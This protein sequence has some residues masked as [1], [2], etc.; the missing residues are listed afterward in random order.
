MYMYVLPG[1]DSL[2]N[3]GPGNYVEKGPRKSNELPFNSKIQQFCIDFGTAHRAI[4]PIARPASLPLCVLVLCGVS[5]QGKL[6]ISSSFFTEMYV[7]AKLKL[8]QSNTQKSQED[9]CIIIF[10]FSNPSDNNWID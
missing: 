2:K 4:A 9:P 10:N 5:K 8:L 7:F 1:A 3:Q 6:E